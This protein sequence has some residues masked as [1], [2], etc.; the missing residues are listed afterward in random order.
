MKFANLVLEKPAEQI[1]EH[2]NLFLR[3]IPILHGKSVGGEEL[4]PVFEGGG[5]NL[6]D[7]FNT[8]PMPFIARQTVPLCP[9]SIPIHDDGNMD[10]W[11][12]EPR[13]F[14]FVHR[15]FLFGV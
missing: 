2:A 4:D 1:H 7:F 9:P 14:A 12:V 10:G 6:P 13:I 5:K 8:A 15:W 11:F 3:S